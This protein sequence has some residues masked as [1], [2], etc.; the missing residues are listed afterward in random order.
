MLI[1][2][3]E[4]RKKF[5]GCLRGVNNFFRFVVLFMLALV[6]NGSLVESRIASFPARYLYLSYNRGKFVTVNLEG[7]DKSLKM[8]YICEGPINDSFP[9]I[10]YECCFNYRMD[11]DANHGTFDFYGIQQAFVAKGR[12]FCTFDKPGVGWSGM[13]CY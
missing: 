13:C 11:A 12:R 9:V 4:T 6:T 5:S 1:E 7:T 3:S 8:H 2:V 10:W